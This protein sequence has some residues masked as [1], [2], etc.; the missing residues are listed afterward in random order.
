[1]QAVAPSGE[2]GELYISI[3]LTGLSPR[4]QEV[5]ARLENRNTFICLANMEFYEFT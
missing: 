3:T 1:M 5:A 2:C 4:Q